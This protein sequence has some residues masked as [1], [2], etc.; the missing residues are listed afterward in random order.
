MSLSLSSGRGW[1]LPFGQGLEVDGQRLFLWVGRASV[2][3]LG[4]QVA[5]QHP[6]KHQQDPQDIG[7]HPLGG[8]LRVG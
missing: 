7:Q 1:G 2:L 4:D 3:L 5:Q 8:E 6:E